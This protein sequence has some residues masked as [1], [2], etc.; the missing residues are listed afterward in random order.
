MKK[1]TQI[2]ILAFIGVVT[3][4]TAKAQTYDPL[5]VQ[6]IN[7]LY[8]NNGLWVTGTPDDPE[9]WW[10]ATWNNESPKQIIE[11][12][13]SKIHHIQLIGDAS[14]AGLTTLQL[15]IC[16]YGNL[17]GL[18]LSNCTALKELWCSGNSLTELDVTDCTQ[19]NY[20]VCSENKLTEL[21]V[22]NCTAMQTMYCYDNNLTALD[23]TGCYK[24]NT[25]NGSSQRRLNTLYENETGDYTCNISLNNPTFGNNA[26]SYSSG[27]LKSSN[28]TVDYTS[29]SVKTNKEGFEL[30]GKLLLNYYGVQMYDPYAVEVINNLIVNN[31]LNATPNLPQTWDFAT[32]NYEMPKQIIELFFPSFYSGWPYSLSGDVSLAGL[33]AL[34]K[35]DCSVSPKKSQMSNPEELATMTSM[36]L[37]NLM[38]QTV[39]LC[40]L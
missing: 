37:P 1:G 10:F 25:F 39:P 14:F 7:D 5:A 24:L 30:S 11:L 34:E 40:I 18:D 28:I 13:F 23:L 15:L 26:I 31:G 33:T 17:T 3:V 38:W 27:I 8:V 20:L 12:N 16:Y 6:R 19:L 32:W 21:K 4:N 9:T 2:L 22:T 35:L 36:L 29:F